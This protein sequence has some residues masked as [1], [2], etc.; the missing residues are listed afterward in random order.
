MSVIFLLIAA[1]TLVAAVF[2]AAFIRAVRSG[3]YD[4]DRSPA[5]RMLHDP[6]PSTNSSL[7]PAPP[8]QGKGAIH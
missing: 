3:Q 7:N 5:V 4:D 6:T 2:L 1:S 8:P